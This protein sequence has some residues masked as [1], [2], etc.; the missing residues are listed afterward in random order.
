MNEKGLFPIFDSGRSP[1]SPGRVAEDGSGKG[2]ENFRKMF[3]KF[4]LN[5]GDIFYE[6][7]AKFLAKW[8]RNFSK[9]VCEI[10]RKMAATLWAQPRGSELFAKFFFLFFFSRGT[11]SVRGGAG[12]KRGWSGG[13]LQAR[14]GVD[15]REKFTLQSGQSQSTKENIFFVLSLP[16]L[17]NS[18]LG[19][20][21]ALSNCVSTNCLLYPCLI[22]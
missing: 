6:M 2:V 1:C 17:S 14:G 21:L 20:F 3:A 22:R 9:D 8:W 10:F 15:G 5:G 19:I 4:L 18:S 11:M 16:V 12:R 13:T 7:V